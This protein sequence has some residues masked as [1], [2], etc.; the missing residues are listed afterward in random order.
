MIG[1]KKHKRKQPIP[2][3]FLAVMIFS[4]LFPMIYPQK[5]RAQEIESQSEQETSIQ[6]T[7]IQD[8]KSQDKQQTKRRTVRV[9]FPEQAGMSSID[10][11]GRISGYNYDYLEKISEFTGWEME[12]VAYPGENGNEAV[13]NAIQDLQD[14]NVD[15]LGPMLKNEQT[16]EMFEYAENSY[17]TV[18]TTLCAPLN[19]QLKEGSIRNGIVVKVGLW[20]Q[21]KT[22]NQE[23]LHFLE[24]ENA[25]YQIIYY[26]T[27]EEQMAALTNGDVDLVSSLSL[28]PIVNTRII[29]KFA[30][31]PYYFVSTKGNTQLIKELDDAIA[32]INRLQPRLQDS[33]FDQYFMSIQSTFSM[34]DAQEQ[35]FG[36]LSDIQ[37]LCV[38]KDAPYVYSKDG[39]PQGALVFMLNDFAKASGVTLHYTFCDSRAEAEEKI[40]SGQFNIVMGMP[41]TSSYCSQ[42]GFVKSESVL[43]SGLAYVKGSGQTKTGKIAVVSGLD[44]MIDTSDFDQVILYDNA[45]QCID[46]LKSE[47]IDA[48]AGDRSVMEYYI[49]ESGSNVVTSLIAGGSQ[50]ICIA[51]SRELSGTFLEVLN[52]YIYSLSDMAKTAYLDEGN[53]HSERESLIRYIARHPVISS[54]VIGGITALVV[55]ALLM[56]VYSVQISRKNQQLRQANEAKTRFLSRMSHDIRTPLNGIIGLLKIDEAHFDEPELIQANH[57]KIKIAANHLLS[58][59]NDVLQ[60]SKLEDAETTLAHEPLSLEEQTKKIRVIIGERATEEGI[61]FTTDEIEY[62]ISEVY[63]SPLHLRQI[64]LNIY[65]NCI[66]YNKPGGSV[67]TSLEYLGEKNGIVTYRWTISDTGVGMSEEFVKHIFD[68]FVQERVDARSVYMGTGLGMSIVK[69]LL[70]KMGGSIEITSKKDVGSTFVITIPFEM[71]KEPT[72][73]EKDHAEKNKELADY[74]KES[75]DHD[76]E[77]F[78]FYEE[79]D[80]KTAS[81]DK[82]AFKMDISG[83]RLLLVEDNELNM[84]IARMLLTDA[85]AIITEVTDGKQ[86]LDLFKDSKPGS[87]DAILMDVMMPVMDGL[88]ATRKIR[89]LPG[90]EAKTIPIIAMTAN[91]F[92]EDAKQ[93]FEAGM[94]AHLTKPLH[95]EVLIRTVAQ[96]CNERAYKKK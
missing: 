30:A 89:A 71:V 58:L 60:M 57:E 28:S 51:V 37:V 46:A 2:F 73:A 44:G 23:V 26:E 76:R 68:P 31:R 88:T 59:I 67:S 49:Y 75:D 47:K 48:A 61:A 19:S 12:Y 16:M 54:L 78:G 22:R 20:E 95:I 65:G 14:G 17:G 50:N 27:Q 52:N 21:A 10:H 93:C 77:A 94:N 18:Y 3:I 4:I 91:A 33:L 84:E 36:L 55:A 42:I 64:F 40:A 38:D 87:F 41:F 85:G 79:N 53:K 35:I 69:N 32:Q 92:E 90:E 83:L 9:A 96:L 39:E 43:T 6:E 86:A 82:E 81:S 1:Q 62:P 24:S 72:S 25:S 13:G 34:T 5:T 8:E 29:E 80:K 56:T 11:N 66:K 7:E 70:D 74:D 15:L 45:K 63:G